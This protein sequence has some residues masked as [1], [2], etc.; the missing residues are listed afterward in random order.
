MQSVVMLITLEELFHL[1]CAGDQLKCLVGA[2][3]GY[4][5]RRWD[6]PYVEPRV[7]CAQDPPNTLETEEDEY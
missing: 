1:V 5:P 4:I 3:K 7:K 6:P 2:S